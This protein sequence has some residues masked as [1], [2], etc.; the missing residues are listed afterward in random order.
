MNANSPSSPPFAYLKGVQDFYGRDFMVTKDV[1][2]P[3]PETEQL[4]DSILY[5]A[6]KPYL[7]GVKPSPRRLKEAPIILDVGTG[8]G[9][10]AITL[11]K[12]LPEATIYATDISEAALKI[13]EQN[14]KKHNAHIH[15]IIS[16]LL[17][18]VKEGTI[19]TPDLVIANLPYVNKNWPW[20]DIASLSY[21]PATALFAENDGLTLI[22][23]LI[24][25][26]AKLR[27]QLL[28]LESDPCQHHYLTK[29]ASEHHYLLADTRG[30]SNTY[31]LNAD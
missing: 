29:Y 10:I 19:P 6:G 20:L 5:L 8:S 21:E 4:I 7:P 31:R 11:K 28:V 22:E 13:A 23:E 27:I 15:L 9:C 18:K 25:Q 2:I 16:H 14:A 24:R 1:L 26:A 30:F 17:D 3:R 12:E